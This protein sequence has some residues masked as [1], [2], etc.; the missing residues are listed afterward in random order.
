MDKEGKVKLAGTQTGYMGDVIEAELA[1]PGSQPLTPLQKKFVDWWKQQLVAT[2]AMLD[3]EGVKYITDEEGNR[4][5]P[6]D[7]YFPRPATGKEGVEAAKGETAKTRVGTEQFFQKERQFPTEAKGR[8]AGIKYEPDEYTR[9]GRYLT[10]VY[11]SIADKRLA[12]D[13]VMGGRKGKPS[14]MDDGIVYHPAFHGR[15]FDA[16]TAPLIPW[17]G[18]VSDPIVTPLLKVLRAVNVLE[19]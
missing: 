1:N 4:V 12:T 13:P 14:F 2:K 18:P 7:V 10:A 8:E 17:S 3:A 5:K 6:S 15:V 16:E 11:R 9:I 19:V